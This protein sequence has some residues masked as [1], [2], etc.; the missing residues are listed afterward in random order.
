MLT[1]IGRL[2]NTLLHEMC[3]VATRLLDDFERDHHGP[4]FKKW[5]AVVH[6]RVP[7]ITITT[8]HTYEAHKPFIYQCTG[9]KCK[10]KFKRH[11][12]KGIDVTKY[13]IVLFRSTL[14]DIENYVKQTYM[15]GV[16][17]R[18]RVYRKVR[19][20]WNGNSDYDIYAKYL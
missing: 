5:A 16:Q 20:G 8:Y 2:K 4:M 10:T 15:R 1:D 6:R 13:E 19:Y 9:E 18:F 14:F 3:H 11:S 7:E 17:R 12:K